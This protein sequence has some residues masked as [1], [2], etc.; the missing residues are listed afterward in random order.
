MSRLHH[1]HRTARLKRSAERDRA[2]E[3]TR[4]FEVSEKEAVFGYDDAAIR[5]VQLHVLQDVAVPVR[6]EH[7]EIVHGRDTRYRDVYS[8]PPWDRE[9]ALEA[10]A[11]V[12]RHVDWRAN[13]RA[14]LVLNGSDNLAILNHTKRAADVPKLRHLSNS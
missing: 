3:R 4:E 14:S 10:V 7:L 1:L 5:I 2:V 13:E 9:E 8:S 11:I 6:Q 12:V